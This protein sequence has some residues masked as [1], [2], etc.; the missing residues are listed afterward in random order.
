MPEKRCESK[1]NVQDD[2]TFAGNIDF[3]ERF[4]RSR[5]KLFPDTDFSFSTCNRSCRFV[6]LSVDDNL[7][8]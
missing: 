1:E 5:R 8:S 3:V 7:V 2:R 6:R 4:A